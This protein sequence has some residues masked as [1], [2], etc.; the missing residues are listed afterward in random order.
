MSS[1]SPPPPPSTSSRHLLVFPYPAQGHMLPLLDLTRRLASYGFTITVLVT[2]KNLSLLQPLLSTHPSV[3]TLVLPFPPHPKLPPGVEHVRDIGNLGNFPIMLAL[4]ELHGPILH[5]FDSHPSPPVAIISDFFLG[6]T[7]RLADDLGIPRIVFYSSGAF[8]VNVVDYCWVHIKTDYF[9]SS[10]VIEICSIPKSPS[11]K[12]EHLPSMV[13]AY[14]DSDPDS[15]LLRD[16][17]MINKSSWATIFNTFEKLEHEHLEHLR[18]VRG[19]G[20][21]FGVGP[22]CLIGA[23]DGRNPI[24]D[25]SSDVLKWL[26]GCPDGSVLYVCFGSQKQLNQQQTEALASGLEKS[27]ARFVW[28]VKTI[29][30]EGGSDGIPIGFEDRV[31]DRGF[32]VKEWAPQVLILNHQAVGGFLSHCGWNS[33]LESIVAG[34]MILGWPMEADQFI[35]ARLLVDDMGVSVRVCEGANSVPDPDELGKVIAKS[36]RGESPEKMKAKA[37]RREAVDAMGTN[38]SSWNDMHDLVNKLNE[39]P[40]ST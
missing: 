10:P 40:P 6:W 36:L 37:L 26:D 39:L 11:F 23:E 27:G 5:W 31:S 20:S 9:R 13:R 12:K 30:T 3:H 22:L 38:G 25:L 4:R 7:Q 1:S 2:P 29:Q 16:S 19:E 35:N 32:V 14:K 8:F 18:K 34:V 24:R 21:V 15:D 28:V 33:V 17:A